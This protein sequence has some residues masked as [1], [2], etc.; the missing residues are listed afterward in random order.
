MLKL[1]SPRNTP[2]PLSFTRL[3]TGCIV[4]SSHSTNQDGYFRYAFGGRKGI[5]KMFHRFIWEHHNGP[6]PPGHEINHM[7]QNRGCCN[8]KHLECLSRT[9]HLVL[10]NTHR[11]RAPSG[12]LMK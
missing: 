8:V 3:P 4:S 10:T 2:R 6:I 11:Y 1:H 9:E 7:C 12:K 5:A